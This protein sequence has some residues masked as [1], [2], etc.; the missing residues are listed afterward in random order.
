M[1]GFHLIDV[2]SPENDEFL[3]AIEEEYDYY[4][5]EEQEHEYTKRMYDFG[6]EHL[7]ELP[8]REMNKE[9]KK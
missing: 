9:K 4:I 6:V 2:Y 3:E 5:W 7:S 8:C 1:G